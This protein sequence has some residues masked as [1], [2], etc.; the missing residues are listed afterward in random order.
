M[1]ALSIFVDSP[2]DLF[3][4][5]SH[6]NQMGFATYLYDKYQCEM[7]DL[8]T[9]ALSLEEQLTRTCLSSN[10]YIPQWIKKDIDTSILIII[11]SPGYDDIIKYANE[12]AKYVLAFEDTTDL[13]DVI[14]INNWGQIIS[15]LKNL[16]T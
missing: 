1:Y 4:F 6:I 3:L 12:K 13:V 9:D 15:F 2:V 10:L 5:D 7:N 11:A 16:K 14:K 8:N